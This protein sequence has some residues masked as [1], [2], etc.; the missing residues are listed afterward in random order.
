MFVLHVTKKKS[1]RG[2]KKGARMKA[3]KKR[4]YDEIMLVGLVLT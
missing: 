2:E 3:K 4:E 1:S